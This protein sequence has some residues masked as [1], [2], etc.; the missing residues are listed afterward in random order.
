MPLSRKTLAFVGLVGIWPSGLAA[1]PRQWIEPKISR[2]SPNAARR[3]YRG[4]D[5]SLSKIP[6]QHTDSVGCA[7]RGFWRRTS[8]PT[9]AATSLRATERAAQFGGVGTTGI[10]ESRSP[11]RDHVNRFQTLEEGFRGRSSSVGCEWPCAST[12]R[13]DRAHRAR[14]TEDPRITRTKT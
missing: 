14:S 7:P 9:G 6:R 13:R 8:S 1:A 4:V 5:R 11:C 2:K 12:H 10:S 3:F